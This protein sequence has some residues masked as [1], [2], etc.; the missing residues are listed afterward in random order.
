MYIQMFE[1]IN[2]EKN[3]YIYRHVASDY[4]ALGS[5]YGLKQIILDNFLINMLFVWEKPMKIYIHKC[6][7]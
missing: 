2:K 3:I 1:K 6:K 7:L 5:Q 4:D